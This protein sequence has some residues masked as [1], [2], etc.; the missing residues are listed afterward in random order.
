MRAVTF[1]AAGLGLAAAATTGCAKPAAVQR[2]S[3]S[4]E[5]VAKIVDGQTTEAEIREWFGPTS[6]VVMTTTG[7]VLT[8]QLKKEAGGVL[9]SLPL[10]GSGGGSS[11]GQLLIVTL[12][13][14]GTVVR[15]AYFGSP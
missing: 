2:A 14:K 6:D 10:L 1:V 4:S 15:H 5:A 3:F 11:S 9:S 8:Y 7:K 13:D 12:D